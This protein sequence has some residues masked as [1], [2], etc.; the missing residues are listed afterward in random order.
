MT[1]P[2]DPTRNKPPIPPP[3]PDDLIE[4]D[5]GPAELVVAAAVALD[6]D[7][8]DEDDLVLPEDEALD[9]R[10]VWEP[11]DDLD[12]AEMPDPS[13][14]AAPPETDPWDA[15]NDLDEADFPLDTAPADAPEQ[16][17]WGPL[18]GPDSSAAPPP[19]GFPIL[20]PPA[21]ATLLLPT[22]ALRR[23]AP[24]PRT[25]PWRL[26]AQVTHPVHARL[27]AVAAPRSEVSRLLVASWEWADTECEH[28]RFRLTDDGDDTI[29]RVAHAGQAVIALTL[30]MQG[31]LFEVEADV[32][33]DRGERGLLLG[34]DALADRFLVDAGRED[35]P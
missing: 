14:I 13:Q 33:A 1:G 28:L 30:R 27:L 32:A 5:E 11:V 20:P 17:P 10:S 7:D 9:D 6:E 23:E 25:I 34:R 19:S 24:A 26:P 16:D 31:V 22:S 8:D 35:W 15:A 12:E 4:D 3:P 18:P 2:T 29:V 21:A